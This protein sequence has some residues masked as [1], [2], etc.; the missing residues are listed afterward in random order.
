MSVS[1]ETG[2]FFM[3]SSQQSG[4]VFDLKNI[5]HDK[6]TGFIFEAGIFYY[7]F[8]MKIGFLPKHLRL[9]SFL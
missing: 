3:A 7:S 5:Y 2:I 4:K 1:K 9:E 8:G 6:Y